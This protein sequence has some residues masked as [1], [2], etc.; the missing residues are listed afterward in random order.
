M[1][2]VQ[3]VGGGSV[4]SLDDCMGTPHQLSSLVSTGLSKY[5]N[6]SRTGIAIGGWHTISGLKRAFPDG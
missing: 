2:V 3:A 1:A 4:T 5:P 6:R